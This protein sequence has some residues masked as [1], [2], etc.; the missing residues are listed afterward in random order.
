VCGGW[1][2][3]FFRDCAAGLDREAL[4]D[5]MRNHK[6]S[7]VKTVNVYIPDRTPPSLSLFLDENADKEPIST[8]V[9]AL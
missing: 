5:I 7:R 1:W 9:T 2:R 8:T 6:D 3:Y 4:I